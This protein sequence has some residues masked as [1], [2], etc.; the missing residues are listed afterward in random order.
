[1][2]FHSPGAGFLADG[3]VEGY[4]PSGDVKGENTSVGVSWVW[5]GRSV[6]FG[7]LAFFLFFFFL[8]KN[9]GRCRR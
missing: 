8:S 6:S 2:L 3:M 4:G 5:G 7:G 1:M 9:G